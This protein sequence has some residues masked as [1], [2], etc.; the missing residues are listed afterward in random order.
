MGFE[1]LGKNELAAK[2]KV[3]S[4]RVNDVTREI[5]LIEEIARIN[6]YDKIE[7]TL[8]RKTVAP[9]FSVE[10]QLISNI[11]NMF[12]GSGFYEAVN[13][14]LIGEPLLKEFML[15]YDKEKAVKV[16]NPQSEDHTML[17]QTLIPNILTNTKIYSITITQI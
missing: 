6:G 3:P 11:K 9:E 13:S 12:L 14:S 5:D 7:V 8:P 2:F 16:T 1:L 10:N 17:R 15:D 4:Y